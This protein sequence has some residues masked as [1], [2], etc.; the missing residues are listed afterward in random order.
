M[1]KLSDYQYE[2]GIGYIA[3]TPAVPT[4]HSKLLVPSGISFHDYHFYDLPKILTKKD[5]LFFNDTKVVKAR[6]PLEEVFVELP[7]HTSASRLVDK[8]ELFFLHLYDAHRFEGLV[9][10]TKRVRKWARIHF[11]SRIIITVEELTDKG[12]IFSI[13]GANVLDFFEKYGQLPLPPYIRYKPEKEESYQTIFAHTLGSVAAPTASLH[14]TDQVMKDLKG[15]KI[16]SHYLTLHVGLGTFK[17][18]DT[19]DIRDYHMH[20]ETMIISEDIFDT[21]AREKEQENNVVAVGT[22]IARTIETLPYLYKAMGKQGNEYRDNLTKNISEQQCKICILDRKQ[23]GKKITCQTK[24][25]IY[26]W[27]ERKI[28][29]GLITNFHLPGSTLLMLVASFIGYDETTKLYK[30]A[31]ANQY[32]FFSFGDA[33]LLH[34]NIN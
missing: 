22:T 29:D 26:P 32:R 30:H 31:I 15:K 5:V 21:I 10:L 9:T 7:H 27:F 17:P 12:V 11:S 18:V 19:E 16:R 4:D 1:F 34:R 3:Q 8:G 24:I 20:E 33:M 2:L 23:E 28:V 25:F 6:V 13:E 14:F